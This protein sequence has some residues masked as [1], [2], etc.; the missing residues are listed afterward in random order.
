MKRLLRSAAV[1]TTLGWLLAGY[2]RLIM[3]TVR[4][5]REGLECVEPTLTSRE[6]AIC[7][8]WHGRIPLSLNMAP[9]WWRRDT[10]VLISPSADGEFIA[11]ALARSGF[12]A[13]RGSSAKK[14]ADAAKT[15]GAAIAFR[16]ALSWLKG[17]GALV[18]TPDGPRGPNE[19]IA[20][21]AVQIAKRSG[22]RVFLVGVAAR[23]AFRV[24]SWDRSM[25]AL[26]F[27][28]GAAV[29]VGPLTAPRDADETAV[30][31]LVADWS[32]RLREATRRA[33]A[34]IA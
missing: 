13:I 21:G 11:Q 30:E 23:P 5:R 3:S 2:L 19:V 6:P 15:R 18:I 34:L 16:E 10:R 25:V 14:G 4:W 26:P 20:P 29:W 24:N 27:G 7:L 28:R 8:L 33:E 17:G 32:A 12:P 9:Q 31:A 1:Q 22:A